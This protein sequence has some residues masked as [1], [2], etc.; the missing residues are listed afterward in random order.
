LD[1]AQ[2]R[3]EARRIPERSARAVERFLY[4]DRKD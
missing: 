4:C 2:T 1:D 3:R